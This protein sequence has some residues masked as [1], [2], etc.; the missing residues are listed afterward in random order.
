MS[1]LIK[2]TNELNIE[3]TYL[4][5]IHLE[6]AIVHKPAENFVNLLFTPQSIIISYIDC[7]LH[8]GF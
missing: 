4:I 7:F 3:I 5:K 8:I 1:T 6:I 2:V